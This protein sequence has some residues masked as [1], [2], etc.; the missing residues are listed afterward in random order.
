MSPVVCWFGNSLDIKDCLIEPAVEFKDK[1]PH[2]SEEW[3]VSYYTRKTAN[4]ITR[5]KQ[6]NPQYGGSVNDASVLR[7]LLEL[8]K[9]ELNIMFYPMFQMDIPGKAWRG[10]V[11]GR[12]IA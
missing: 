6:D 7:Y 5:D 10:R 12:A 3:R 4:E 8:K 11:T 9:R 1:K 2:Y